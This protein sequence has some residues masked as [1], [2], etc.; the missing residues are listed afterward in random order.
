MLQNKSTLF[1]FYYYY[2][3]R[4]FHCACCCVRGEIKLDCH[5]FVSMMIAVLLVDIVFISPSL[6]ITPHGR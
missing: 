5:S 6:S 2:Y 4:I 1:I 3:F